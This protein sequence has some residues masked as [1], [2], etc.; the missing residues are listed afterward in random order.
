M[1][2]LE[3]YIAGKSYMIGHEPSTADTKVLEL[4]TTNLGTSCENAY[5]NENTS[6]VN[7]QTHRV[8]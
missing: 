2:E 8:T 6:D 7:N 3:N 4:L 5:T 1:C